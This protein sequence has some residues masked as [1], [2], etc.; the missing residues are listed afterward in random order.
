MRSVILKEQRS[1]S[2]V[3]REAS[4]KELFD[5]LSELPQWRKAKTVFLFVGVLPEPNTAL[6]LPRLISGG[7]RIAAPLSAA[8]GRMEARQITD[9]EQLKPGRFGI[10]EP[11]EGCPLV[12]KEEIEL[13]LV[14][15]LCYDRRGFRLGRGGGYYDRYLAE[16]RGVSVGLC[17]E[18]FLQKRLPV[19]P[20][21]KWVDFVLT[22]REIISCAAGGAW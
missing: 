13:V 1:M 9:V 6:L 21:D 15:A 4:D 3:G 18:N 7:V 14:P 17:R 5:Q 19:L 11:Q 22:E 16:Y 10:L 8:S 2:R 12:S 20:H